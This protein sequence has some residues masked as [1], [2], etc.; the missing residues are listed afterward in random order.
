MG[1][2]PLSRCL[3]SDLINEKKEKKN[4]INAKNKN[5]KLI[6]LN[7]NLPLISIMAATTTR[8]VK[9]PSTSNLALFM[10]LLP[11]LIR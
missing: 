8:K 1:T 5:E 10:F 2:R 11:S 9:K 7:K 6:N 4:E 3:N